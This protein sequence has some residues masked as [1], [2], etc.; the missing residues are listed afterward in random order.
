MFVH[1]HAIL[2]KTFSSANVLDVA[3]RKN[4][5][6]YICRAFL[7]MFC[8]HGL[9]VTVG[10]AWRILGLPRGQAQMSKLVVDNYSRQLNAGS[11]EQSNKI[12]GV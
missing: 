5:M 4:E 7:K 11:P 2:L 9:K 8:N 12:I 6:R 3:T 1:N 10:A